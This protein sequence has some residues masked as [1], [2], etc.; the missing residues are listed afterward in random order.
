MW[1]C[2]TL[3]LVGVDM[4]EDEVV[5]IIERSA[6]VLSFLFLP[7]IK[8]L[9]TFNL[10][11]REELYYLSFYRFLDLSFCYLFHI[12]RIPSLIVS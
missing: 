6:Q 11:V 8:T 10:S 7:F 9:T 4:D 12:V 2:H 1:M 5:A 3:S